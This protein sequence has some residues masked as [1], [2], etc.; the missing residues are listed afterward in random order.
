ME[1]SSKNQ[2]RRRF[3]RLPAAEL[4]AA[5]RLRKAL[6]GGYTPTRSHDF[7]R[8][9]LSITEKADTFKIGDRVELKLQLTMKAS[10]I[11]L[12]RL[13]AEVVNERTLEGD[14]SLTRFGLAFDFTGSRLMRSQQTRAQL[15]R[16]EGILERS[17]KL[18]LRLQ[19]LEN[20]RGLAEQ[21]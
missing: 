10:R 3:R 19:P 15:G 5:W 21:V 18:R 13:I 20:I 8:E 17:E 2:E 16:I 9:G 6:F 1:T 12:E 7:T 14:A 4:H 11:S